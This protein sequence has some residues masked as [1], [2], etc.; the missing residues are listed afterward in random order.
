MMSV[1]EDVIVLDELR[2]KMYQDLR[3]LSL[4]MPV[5]VSIQSCAIA[6]QPTGQ[7]SLFDPPAADVV[8]GYEWPQGSGRCLTVQQLIDSCPVGREGNQVPVTGLDR[9]NKG[10]PLAAARILA[11]SL[12]HLE[13]ISDDEIH[14]EG[15]A[16]WT[17]YAFHWNQRYPKAPWDLNPLCWVI[18]VV[19]G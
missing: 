2:S 12:G 13:D 16:N 3:H 11:V 15:Y 4:R 5:G 10:A 14:A 6:G 8:A 19:Q 7:G 18:R 1:P 17:E 9:Y